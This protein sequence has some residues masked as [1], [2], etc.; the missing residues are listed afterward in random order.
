MEICYL[1]LLA[2]DTKNDYI[3]LQRNDK[4]KNCKRNTS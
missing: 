1:Q 4:K 3:S 2:T